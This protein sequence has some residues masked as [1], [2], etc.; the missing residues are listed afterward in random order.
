ML[1]LYQNDFVSESAF[2]NWSTSEPYECFDITETGPS[3]KQDTT[4]EKVDKTATR[5]KCKEFIEFMNRSDDEDEDED[6]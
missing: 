2:L 6:D 5:T 4:V 1:F 3:G